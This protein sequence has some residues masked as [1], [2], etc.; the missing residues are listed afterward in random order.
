MLH[1]DRHDAWVLTAVLLL[2]VLSRLAWAYGNLSAATYWEDEYRWAAALEL[3]SGPAHPLLDYQAD[4]YQGGS[5]VMILLITGLFQVIGESPLVLKMAAISFGALTLTLLYLVGRRGFGRPTAICV[6]VAY[7]LGPPLVAVSGLSVMGSHGESVVFSLLQ[8]LIF[9]RLLVQEGRSNRTWFA[10]GLVS[11][12]GLWFCYT[13]GLS[14]AA[15]GLAWLALEK[16]PKWPELRSALVGG[17]VGLIPWFAYNVERG[18]VGLG[19]IA[20]VLG[21]SRAPDPWLPQTLTEKTTLLLFQDWP[22]GLLFPFP[23]TRPDG[24]M[25]F[26]LVGFAVPL[27]VALLASVWRVLIRGR[28][29]RFPADVP[30]QDTV[31][32]ERRELVFLI[33]GLLWL[34]FF[35]SSSFTIDPYKGAHEYRLFLPPAILL[36][37][38]A[39]RSAALGLRSPGLARGLTIIGLSC[40]LILSTVGTIAAATR[41]LSQG[42]FRGH[43]GHMVRGLLL[44]RKYETTL[45]EAVS[46]A[47]TID[48]RRKRMAVF[49]GIGWGVAFRFEEGGEIETVHAAIGQIPQ[50]DRAAFR[51]GLRWAARQRKVEEEERLRAGTARIDS[52]LLVSRFDTLLDL[53][54]GPPPQRRPRSRL[55]RPPHLR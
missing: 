19:R 15:C 8:V 55:G 42:A 38:P 35:L 44:H 27:A 39:A 13:S 17:F 16:V 46:V 49:R 45:A 47:K 14:L 5:L 28:R 11:G 41:P 1:L 48:Q 37:L 43:F 10:F 40:F 18:F 34:L 9:F 51:S 2:F 52:A 12:L 25:A 24:L 33:Y 22:V 20:E 6:T 54:G 30:G 31:A 29:L 7:L 32:Y 4:H 23:E 21:M 53:T 50:Q 36:L 3:L 26:A